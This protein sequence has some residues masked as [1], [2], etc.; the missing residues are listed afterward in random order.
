MGKVSMNSDVLIVQSNWLSQKTR[1]W[2]NASSNRVFQH[3]RD[4]ATV[5]R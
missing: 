5:I 1:C 4:V 3:Q 2:R